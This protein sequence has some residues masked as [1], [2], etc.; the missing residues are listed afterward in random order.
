MPA[1]DRADLATSIVQ[2]R[3]A[4][5]KTRDSE[6]RAAL[7]EVEVRL[8]LAL[9]PTI[10]KKKAAAVLGISVTALDRWVDRGFLPV[11]VRP[12]SSRHE[13]ESRPF[14]ELAAQVARLRVD[15][16]VTHRRIAPAVKRLGWRPLTAGRRILRLDVAALPRPNVTEQE[17]VAN[18]RS[19]TPEQRVREAA[20]LSRFLARSLE[21]TERAA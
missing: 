10:P 1:L 5:V 13:L 9:G 11:V 21:S 18:F 7:R 15:G 14:L 16:V 6:A 3:H 19:T 12:G 20:E 17:L 4:I 2:L 8:R